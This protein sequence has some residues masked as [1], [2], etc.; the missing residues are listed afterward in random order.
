MESSSLLVN[1]GKSNLKTDKSAEL[2]ETYSKTD[3]SA[4]S[5]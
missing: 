3:K 1:Y 5:Y 4:E 2:K